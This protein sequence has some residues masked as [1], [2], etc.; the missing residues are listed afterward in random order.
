MINQIET[1]D[2]LAFKIV[3]ILSI[4]FL[5]LGWT[6]L[7]EFLPI[8]AGGFVALTLGILQLAKAFKI[9]S[10]TIQTNKRKKKK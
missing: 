8:A 7:L 3:E 2:K 6:D 4:L 10:E 5:G 1:S 9:I